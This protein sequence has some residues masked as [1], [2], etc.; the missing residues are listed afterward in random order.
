[1]A[2]VKVTVSMDEEVLQRADQYA[3]ANGMT[4][5]GLFALSVRKYL[6]ASEAA[7]A[8]TELA[9]NLIKLFKSASDLPKEELAAMVDQIDADRLKLMK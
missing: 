5:S 1:M 6:E 8:V 2:I 4:R 3:D 9:K 7:P